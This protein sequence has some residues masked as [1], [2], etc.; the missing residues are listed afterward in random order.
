MDDVRLAAPGVLLRPWRAADAPAVL[1][2]LRD[3]AVATWNP[4]GDLDEARAREWVRRRA[5]WSAGDHASLAVA[6]PGDTELLG[7]V[8]LSG[9]GGGHANI[10]YWTAPAAR[11]RGVA[12]AAVRRLT[13]WGFAMLGLHRV[14]LFHAVANPASCRVA[15]RAGYP[16]EGTLRE[17][18][19][20][21]DGRR[22]DEHLH[23]RLATDP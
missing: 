2:A 9:I 16:F 17:S 10:G 4:Q 13:A 21:G 12:T 6:D 5:D 1:A 19:R 20:Y 3:P 22:H 8:S 23:A 7:S 18:H 11:G 14:E 15:E